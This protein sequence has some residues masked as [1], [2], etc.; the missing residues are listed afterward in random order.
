MKQIAS[1]ATEQA[2]VIDN[3]WASLRQYTDARIGLGRAGSSQPT[4]PHLAFQLAHAQARDA[5]HLALDTE[6]M[7]QELAEFGDVIHV[8]SQATDRATYLCRPDLGRRLDAESTERLEQWAASGAPPCLSLVVADGLSARA[9]HENVRAFLNIFVP[10]ARD[11]GWSLGPIVL[12]EQARVALG[13]PVGELLGAEVEVMLIGERPG[14]S[15]PDSLGIYFTYHPHSGCRDSERNC[16]SN[17][18]R[19]GQGYEE[20][21]RLLHYLIREAKALGASGV[22]LKDNSDTSSELGNGRDGNFLLS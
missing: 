20:A 21:A 6:K 2:S 5:V 11:E 7:T 3:P 9:I 14:L 13:D 8:S 16:I 10:M 18:R 22:A 1:D 17:V 15:S 4:Q 19:A 12:A